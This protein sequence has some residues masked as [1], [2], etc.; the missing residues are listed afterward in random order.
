MSE[1]EL[2]T[3]SSSSTYFTGHNSSFN[4]DTDN[5]STELHTCFLDKKN[6]LNLCH[7]NAQSVP[8]HYTE[9]LDTFSSNLISAVLVSESWLKPCLPSTAYSLPGFIL[10]RN[11]RTGK[12]GGGVAIY[13]KSDIPFKIILS[14]PCNYS[15][16]AE[17]LFIEISLGST[18]VA[19]GI[20][21]CPPTVDYFSCLEPVL[22]SL[23]SDYPH[24]I[25]MGDLNTDISRDSHRT[26][27][28]LSLLKSTGLAYLQLFPTHHNINGNDSWID[29]ILTSADQLVNAHGQVP[30]P[31]FSRH[32]LIYASFALKIPKFISR[33]VQLRSY[34]R[35]NLDNLSRDASGIDWTPIQQ[36]H[37][38]D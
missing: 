11:D 26:Q 15:A 5:L 14:S 27:K 29:H 4:S 10:I 22:E 2:L 3:D 7:I 12:G 18:K 33:T 30:A 37:T 20:L 6:N 35:I 34:G 28:L 8:K 25:I 17:Y 21:Y 31:G 36:L 38:F 32:D 9:L 13:L 1:C 16:S 24:L 19:L 23:S